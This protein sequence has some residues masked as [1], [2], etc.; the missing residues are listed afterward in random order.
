MLAFVDYESKSHGVRV[1][2]GLEVCWI[3]SMFIQRFMNE[4]QDSNFD[5]DEWYIETA[6]TLMN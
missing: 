2:Y 5:T 1:A 6:K 4:Y 3:H